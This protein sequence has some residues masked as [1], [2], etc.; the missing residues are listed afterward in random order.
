MLPTWCTL[1]SPT[2]HLDH[3]DKLCT[4]G[5]GVNLKVRP[6]G[7]FLGCIELFQGA[8]SPGLFRHVKYTQ[9]HIIAATW[10]EKARGNGAG[11]E[12]EDGRQRRRRGGGE[13]FE[14]A[15]IEN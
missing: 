15:G 12:H 1:S 4:T 5:P 6:Q 10:R 7:R 3:S 13:G 9:V 8:L 11:G 2:H 14:V